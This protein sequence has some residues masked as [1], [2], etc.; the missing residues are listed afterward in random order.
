M[1]TSLAIA[2]FLCLSGC[3]SYVV[4][5]EERVRQE[6]ADLHQAVAAFKAH[7][8]VRVLPSRIRLA[9]KLADMDRESIDVIFRMFP[10]K[11]FQDAWNK[12]LV[13]ND[14]A[15]GPV[16]L[17]GDQCLVFFLGGPQRGGMP[18]GWALDPNDPTKEGVERKLF[19]EFDRGRLK[20]RAAQVYSSYF[21]PYNF[22]PY[23]YF[24]AP[25]RNTDCQSLGVQPYGRGPVQN[26]DAYHIISA[27]PDGRFGMKGGDWSPSNAALTY[28]KGSDGA[29]DWANF[30]TKPLGQPE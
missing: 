11:G 12:G 26:P 30:H 23:A 1:R 17:E 18:Q 14:Q 22:Q 13:W 19:Y 10:N 27:G 15:T 16:T 29:D 3:K 28:P 8:G 25:F 21:D 2:F 20:R 6:I 9:N 24:A 7:F 5:P 4:Q